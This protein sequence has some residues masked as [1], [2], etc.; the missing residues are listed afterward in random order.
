M[1]MTWDEGEAPALLEVA[2]RDTAE[3]ASRTLPILLALGEV[4]RVTVVSSA[5]HIRVPWF[6]APYRRFGLR[7]GYGPSFAHGSW[8]RMLAEELRQIPRAPA[9]RRAAMAAV[10]VPEYSPPTVAAE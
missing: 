1:K 10:R 6:F 7:V 5:W 4:H 8:G 3:N 2:G 9:R